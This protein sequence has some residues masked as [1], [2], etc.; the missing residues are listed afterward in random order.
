MTRRSMPTMFIVQQAFAEHQDLRNIDSSFHVVPVG[1]WHNDHDLKALGV[2]YRDVLVAY[3]R[4]IGPFL[5]R[6]YDRAQA[7]E[8]VNGFIADLHG[9]EHIV[10]AYY[11]IHAER[12]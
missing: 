11:T 9:N 2:R 1:D 3:A 4:S 7:E 8:L 5:E 12:V 10:S 6:H